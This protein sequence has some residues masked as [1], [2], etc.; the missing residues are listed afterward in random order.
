V[1]LKSLKR[2][3]YLKWLTEAAQ[4]ECFLSTSETLDLHTL[5]QET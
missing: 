4:Y 3:K 5:A 1:S 2:L